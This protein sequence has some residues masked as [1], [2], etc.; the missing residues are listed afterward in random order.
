MCIAFDVAVV[1]Y[2]ELPERSL[3]SLV[4]RFDKQNSLPMRL[5]NFSS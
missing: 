4:A 2:S 1:G 5:S 3:L